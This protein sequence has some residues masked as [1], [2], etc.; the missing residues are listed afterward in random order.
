MAQ[1][2]SGQQAEQEPAIP[3][4]AGIAALEVVWAGVQH[5]GITLYSVLVVSHVD[6]VFILCFWCKKNVDKPELNQQKPPRWGRNPGHARRDCSA[7]PSYCEKGQFLR[8]PVAPQV[9]TWVSVEG[10]GGDAD[11]L[12]TVA[13]AKRVEGSDTSWSPAQAGG[14]EQIFARSPGRLD[15]LWIWGISCLNWV[16]CWASW[17]E[18]RTGSS[19]DKRLD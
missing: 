16:K 17:S 6:S 2:L 12:S 15:C 7:G 9:V 10:S 14:K 19:L 1:N 3:Q 5:R 11:G 8:C 13:R 4:P 18:P